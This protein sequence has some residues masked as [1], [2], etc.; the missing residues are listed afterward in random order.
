[1][2]WPSEQH[3]P[4]VGRDQPGDDVEAGGLAGAVRAQQAHGLAAVQVERDVAQHGAAAI[5]LGQVPRRQD[6]LAGGRPTAGRRRAAAPYRRRGRDHQLGAV[7]AALMA[8]G[9]AGSGTN[10]ARTRCAGR[11]LPSGLLA[12]TDGHAGVAVDV[13]PV[14][15]DHVLARG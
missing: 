8:A 11:P 10:R 5:V 6:R 4:G 15:A 3:L 9:G 13:Q 1:M 7:A 12:V 2:S 14:A